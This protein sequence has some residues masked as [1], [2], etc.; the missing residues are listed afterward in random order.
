MGERELDR[1]GEGSSDVSTTLM[2]TLEPSRAG[3][4]THGKPN[5]FSP[6]SPAPDA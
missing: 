6:A 4:T 3:L 2:P 5:G 1:G